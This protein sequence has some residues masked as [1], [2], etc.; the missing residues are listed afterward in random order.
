MAMDE[1][2]AEDKAQKEFEDRIKENQ[3]EMEEKT[4]PSLVPKYHIGP[5]I[6]IPTLHISE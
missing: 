3:A 4:V 1:K 6:V 2:D 5:F